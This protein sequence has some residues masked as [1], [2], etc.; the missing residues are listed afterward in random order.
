MHYQLEHTQAKLVRCV[1]CVV[2]DVAVDLPESSDHFG[3]WVGREF[4][5]KNKYDRWVRPGFAHGFLTLREI[6]V[7]HYKCS[8]I[9]DPR[10]RRSI[11]WNDPLIGINSACIDEES[12]LVTISKREIEFGKLLADADVF[13]SWAVR[14]EARFQEVLS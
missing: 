1:R 6:T 7:F 8:D 14:S 11:C 5:D 3:E 2:F 12:V 10:S 9:Y 13:S 4:S